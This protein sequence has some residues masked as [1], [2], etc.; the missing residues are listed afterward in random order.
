MAIC[1]RQ[2]Q[3][4]SFACAGYGHERAFERDFG[5]SFLLD[6]SF[7]ADVTGRVTVEP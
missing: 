6:E 1:S 7:I 4:G 5:L 2:R 3:L